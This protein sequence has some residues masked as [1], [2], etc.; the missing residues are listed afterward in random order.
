[1]A[2]KHGVSTALVSKLFKEC[3]DGKHANPFMPKTPKV[4]E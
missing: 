4:G 1:L 2:K 3:R